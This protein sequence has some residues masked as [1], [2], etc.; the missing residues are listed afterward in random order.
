MK[1]INKDLEKTQEIL[2]TGVIVD[3]SITEGH[4]AP[5]EAPIYIV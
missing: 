3:E 4:F 5:K 1:K 2:K